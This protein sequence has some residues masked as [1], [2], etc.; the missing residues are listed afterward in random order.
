LVKEL[1]IPEIPPHGVGSDPFESSQDHLWAELARIDMLV[2][3][4]VIRWRYHIARVKPEKLWGMVNVTEAEVDAYLD[5][6]LYQPRIVPAELALPVQP[7]C[8]A[9]GQIAANIAMAVSRTN[10]RELRVER[11][12]AL[13]GLSKLELDVLLV[14][15][16]PELDGRYRRLFGYLQDDVTRDRPSAEL[17]MQILSP[18]SEPESDPRALRAPFQP[19]SALLANHLVTVHARNDEP[20]PGRALRVDDRIVNYLIGGDVLDARLVGLVEEA[21]GVAGWA[22]LIAESASVERLQAWTAWWKRKRPDGGAVWL[23][24]GRAGNGQIMAANAVCKDIGIPLLVVDVGRAMRA[25]AGW[26]L[27]VDIA[28]R[29]A[30]LRGAA[31]AWSGCQTLLQNDQPPQRWEWLLD[32]A[33]RYEG[34]TFLESSTAWEPSGRFRDRPFLR[35]EFP[36]PSYALRKRLWKAH[37]PPMEAIAPPT[38]KLTSLAESLSNAFQFTE[39][40]VLDALATARSL[41]MVRDPE[42]PALSVDDLF[43]GCRRQSN[44]RLMTF[45]RRIIPRA[46]LG[47]DDLILPRANA[48]Q[49]EELRHRV[50]QRNRVIGGMGFEDRMTMGKGF[51]A[52]FTGS[53]GTGKTMAAE[54]LAHEQGVELFKVDLSAVVSKWVGE[55]EKNLSVVFAEAEASNAVILIDECEALFSKRG[56]VK[57]ARDRWA[58]LE[59]N[60]LLQRIEEYSGVVVLTSNFRQNIDEA[61]LRRIHAI[62][63]FPFPDAIARFKIWK[64]MFPPKLVHPPDDDLR[65]LATRCQLPG[66]SIRNIVLDAA[67]RALGS[68]GNGEPVITVHNLVLS[69]AREYQKLGKPITKADFGEHFYGLIESTLL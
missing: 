42:R 40:Q 22:N 9:A 45:A 32:A 23:L 68:A 19:G 20:L 53:S 44:Q 41:A 4:Q 2:R 14:C 6:V 46:G 59:A 63:E 58:N 15:L 47:F 10:A 57:D 12:R 17:I 35:L 43:E 33:A 48:L 16:L 25:A 36:P 50:A 18:I 1:S 3:A 39:S 21:R 52:L 27:S 54:L 28:Y 69:T 55:T 34:L 61:F 38:P 29:E 11:L 49:I 31:L 8:E 64:G 56:E 66:G 51:V 37:L 62:V 65:D 60:Y 13:C 5:S 30:R 26:E 7:F 24:L 67:F